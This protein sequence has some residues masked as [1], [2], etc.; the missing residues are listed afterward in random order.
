MRRSTFYHE[1][2]ARLLWRSVALAQLASSIYTIIKFGA[3]VCDCPFLKGW[4]IGR[5]RAFSW[6]AHLGASLPA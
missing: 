6:L 5:S 3:G 1:A 4:F 2:G